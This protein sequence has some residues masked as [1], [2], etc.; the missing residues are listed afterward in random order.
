[1]ASQSNLKQKVYNVI[2]ITDPNN[3]ISKFFDVFILSLIIANVI[4]VILETVPELSATYA[5]AFYN[6]ELFSVIIFSSEYL[7]RI[8][9]ITLH[10]DYRG[11]FLGR[12][13]YLFSLMSVIDLAAILP[14]YLPMLITVDL[15][16]A[17]SLRL[18]RLFRL[19]KASRY[20]RALGLIQTVV[21]DKQSEL[22][23]TA[24]LVGILIIIS[25]SALYLLENPGQPEKFSS[26]PQAMWWSISCITSVG[27]GDVYP[28]TPL[29]QIFGAFLALLGVALFALPAGIL[30]SGFDEAIK[31]EKNSKKSVDCPE[32]GKSIQL[33]AETSD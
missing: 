30:A 2:E 9:V 33:N 25:S 24:F 20:T 17:R 12:L 8:W 11:T 13:K 1:M 18:F 7:L 4:A 28:I 21:K 14:F 26:I 16:F 31:E 27:Y 29:G 22:G 32:S 15:R 6:F 19:F 23:I 10:S 5:T 3:K